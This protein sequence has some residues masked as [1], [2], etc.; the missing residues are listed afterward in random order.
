[1]SRLFGTS[2]IRGVVNLELTPELAFKV[3]LAVSTL[4][5]AIKVAVARDTRSSGAM[6]FSALVSG[7]IAGGSNAIDL[8][9]LPTPVLAYLTR[10]L[11]FDVGAMITASHNPPEY[12]GIK[13]FDGKG[14]AYGPLQQSAVENTLK[15]AKFA[16]V[17][18]NSV[19]A[20]DSVNETSRYIKM[21][22]REVHLNKKWNL[23][24]DPG[25]GAA[26]S[27]AAYLLKILGCKTTSMN[28]QPDGFFPGRTPEPSPESLKPLSQLVA[29][30]G[31][32]LGIAYD[33]D[34]DRVAFV[35]ERGIF[36]SFD[37][38]LAAMAGHYLKKNRG[39]IVV[40]PIDTSMCIDEIAVR[41]HGKVERTAVG[42]VEVAW[43]IEEKRAVFGG[44]PCG[45]WINPKFHMCPDGILSSIMF[46]HALETEN[47][48]ASLLISRVPQYPI[49]R[50][51]VNCPIMA[52]DSVMTRLRDR[53]MKQF[54]ENVEISTLDGIR[55]STSGWW[56]LVRP[57]G[58][59]PTI[60][61]TVEAK[62][63]K[64]AKD[65]LKLAEDEVSTAVMEV[66]S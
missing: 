31:A 28:S 47:T 55:F 60:R 64:T 8:G 41:E 25:C 58:T 26:Y 7:V 20:L 15:S 9:V 52:K 39:G 1:L 42:D 36:M 48:S 49:M 44:E 63:E 56:M 61:V 16:M 23:V 14:I 6:L 2:G 40:T 65:L 18:W 38:S 19:G 10:A 59:E 37:R 3:G 17:P 50:A 46:L 32:D 43:A 53:F 62:D 35:D 34:A 4:N 5:R 54:R 66:D 29:Q 33:G 11:R 30:S 27:L 57:S 22:C 24:V 21:I 13:L 51:K 12:G 45:A